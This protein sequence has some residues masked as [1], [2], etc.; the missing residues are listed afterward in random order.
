MSDFLKSMRELEPIILDSKNLV[1]LTGAGVSRESGIPTF[2]GNEGLWKTHDPVKLSSLSA[3]IENPLLVWDF[4]C[5]RIKLISTCYPNEAHIAISKIQEHKRNS[6]VL[7]QN[8]DNLHRKAGN[9]NIIELHGNIFTAKCIRCNYNRNVDEKLEVK[10]PPSCPYCNDIIKP[11]VVLFEE[12]LPQKEWTIAREICSSCDLMFV[13]GTSLN[14]YPVN[15]LPLYAKNNNAVIVEINTESTPL[16][17]F[18]NFSFRGT[19]SK[20]VPQIKNLLEKNKLSES[21]S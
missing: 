18:T 15:S 8:I 6:W 13:I 16:T 20:I 5:D 12:S 7:T 1:F 21:L 9:N 2:R 11:G 10:I 3:F 17:R 14:V 19:A 4:Y